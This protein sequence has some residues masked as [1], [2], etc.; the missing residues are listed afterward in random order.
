MMHYSEYISIDS[1]IR[2]GKPCIKGTRISVYDVLNWMASGMSISD[3]IIDDYSSL[4]RNGISSAI[5]V[6]L[7]TMVFI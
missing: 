4:A 3:I 2:F 7:I 5:L 6:F 1:Q